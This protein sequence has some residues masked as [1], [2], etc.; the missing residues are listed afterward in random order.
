M[1]LDFSDMTSITATSEF[2]GDIILTEVNSDSANFINQLNKET[3]SLKLGSSKKINHEGHEVHEEEVLGYK[4][5]RV[6]FGHSKLTVIFVM[7]GM[8]SRL[9]GNDRFLRE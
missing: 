1:K 4:C 2:Q 9:R 7:S 6:F 5:Y 3:F 8:D